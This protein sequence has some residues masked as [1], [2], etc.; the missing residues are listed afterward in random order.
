MFVNLRGQSDYHLGLTIYFPKKE[1]QNS[2]IFPKTYS[3]NISTSDLIS[4]V[5]TK[6]QDNENLKSN[7]YIAWVSGNTGIDSTFDPD[8]LEY[9]GYR[10][11]ASSNSVDLNIKIN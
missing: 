3:D 2:T 10:G 9:F 1:I 7:T 5:L 6:I 4:K 8:T 11:L